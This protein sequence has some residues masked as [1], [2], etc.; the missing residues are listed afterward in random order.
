[1]CW[2]AHGWPPPPPL[3][4][5][6][7][8]SEPLNLRGGHLEM[9]V[10]STRQW[11]AAPEVARK[12]AERGSGASS[13]TRPASAA[14]ERGSLGKGRGKRSNGQHSS[15]GSVG[16][17]ASPHAAGGGGLQGSMAAAA[18]PMR[19]Q[20]PPIIG[21]MLPPSAG[22]SSM[23]VHWVAVPKAMRARRANRRRTWPLGGT[24][25]AARAGGGGGSPRN[26]VV[27][28]VVVPP[29]PGGGTSAAPA[30]CG[31]TRTGLAAYRR[32]IRGRGVGRLD[33]DDGDV[34]RTAAAA[35]TTTAAAAAAA[36]VALGPPSC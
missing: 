27:V 19:R 36:A 2:G 21:Q 1:L 11:V 18:H 10:P 12:V 8:V 16:A 4:S 33:G 17:A 9:W 20:Q 15:Q 13:R 5:A 14:A 29:T 24:H 7:G 26:V 32:R 30:P 25:R 31:P 6:Q 28:V 23:R 35:T 34:V 22:E 3:C